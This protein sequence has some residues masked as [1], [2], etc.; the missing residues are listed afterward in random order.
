MIANEFGEGP[1]KKIERFPSAETAIENLRAV[2]EK[3][4]VFLFDDPIPRVAEQRDAMEE[5]QDR[6]D[7][8]AEVA[9]ELE[10]TLR[11]S[12]HS[13]ELDLMTKGAFRTYRALVNALAKAKE[14]F[15]H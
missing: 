7:E 3:G 4:A 10:R 9:D 5:L 1:A 11:E 2:H 15:G 14:E 12:G 6:L 8:A 13:E